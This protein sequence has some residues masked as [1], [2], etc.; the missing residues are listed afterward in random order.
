MFSSSVTAKGGAS[1][2]NIG[3]E[4]AKP[5][6]ITVGTSEYFEN[7]IKAIDVSIERRQNALEIKTA[8]KSNAEARLSA[9]IEKLNHF[10]LSKKRTLAMMEEMKKTSDESS[11]EK[12]ALFQKS[13][14][15]AEK[16]IHDLKDEKAVQ[17]TAINKIKADIKLYTNN[18]KESVEEKFTLKRLNQ[19]TPPKPIVDI[20]GKAFSGTRINGRFANIIL[21]QTLS[22]SRIIEVNS[23]GD[24]KAKRGWEMIITGF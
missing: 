24:E 5:S 23:S 7:Q 4:K 8:E 12:I 17:E 18:V 13:L 6:T 16:K 1:I 15:E 19:S 22:R 10:D 2:Y 14:D 11:D 20:S 21:S 3:S 9:I